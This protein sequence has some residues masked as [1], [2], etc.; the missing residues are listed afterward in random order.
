M[1]NIISYLYESLIY[2]AVSSQKLFVFLDKP[3]A[4]DAY[5]R[6]SGGATSNGGGW[7]KRTPEDLSQLLTSFREI[8]VKLSSSSPS[9]SSSTVPNHPGGNIANGSTTTNTTT[10]SITTTAATA[11]SVDGCRCWYDQ[12]VST[13]AQVFPYCTAPITSTA[14]ASA[15]ASATNGTTSSA[16][17]SSGATAI[18]ANRSADAGASAS[19]IGTSDVRD[20]H[21][22]LF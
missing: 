16:S 12:L 22:C 5:Y 3:R 2:L 13:V 1:N 8:Q 7:V 9:T 10:A 6:S 15:S 20:T 19:V 21:G 18:A 14:S 4:Y 17:A 11:G